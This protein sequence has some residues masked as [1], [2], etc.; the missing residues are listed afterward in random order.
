MFYMSPVPR[1]C[2]PAPRMP[3]TQLAQKAHMV[4]DVLC[5]HLR[6][7]WGITL[8]AQATESPFYR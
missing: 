7:S 3:G 8:L 5:M 6:E 4:Y 2:P 1:P